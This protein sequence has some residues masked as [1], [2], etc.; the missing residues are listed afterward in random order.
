MS[1]YTNNEKELCCPLCGDN[2]VHI[3]EV[4]VA[5]RPQGE[6]GPEVG[7]RVTAKGEVFD[8]HVPT[9]RQVGT[10]R[11]HRIALIGWCEQCEGRRFALVFTQHKGVTFVESVE[12]PDQIGE[13]AA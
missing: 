11:R 6:D 5:A 2:F 3:D 9:G 12:M 8:E 13:A 7:L 10:G 1:V 4:R